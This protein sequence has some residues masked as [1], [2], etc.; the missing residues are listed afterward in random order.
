[1]AGQAVP[2]SGVNGDAQKAASAAASRLGRSNIWFWFDELLQST[3]TVVPTGWVAANVGAG[4]TAT[5]ITPGSTP[6]GGI[7]TF[8]TAAAAGGLAGMQAQQGQW[9][10]QSRPWHLAGRLR[11]TGVVD[12]ATIA[13]LILL[14]QGGGGNSVGV[15]YFGTNSTTNWSM[16][17]SGAKGGSFSTSPTAFDQTSY[18]VL[19]LWGD[20]VN[21]IYGAVDFGLPWGPATITVALT[22]VQILLPQI[23][24]G[25]T[26]AARTM[27]LD[28]VS[29]AGVR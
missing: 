12:A 3:S 22:G 19:E 10:I 27:E 24:N 23:S 28:W 26:A 13:G 6:D 20:G 2:D 11:V 25:A 21:K 15:G 4:T 1:M 8:N 17:H 9:T 16:Q 7:I 29:W 5:V 18:H 14:D